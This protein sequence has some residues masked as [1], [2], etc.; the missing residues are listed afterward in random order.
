[1]VEII[2]KIR[3]RSPA[4]PYLDLKDA[5]EK[6]EGFYNIQD[7]NRISAVVATKDIGYEAGSSRGWRA[8][9]SLISFG[10]LDEEGVTDKREVWLSELG[11]EIFHYGSKDSDEA[12]KAIR[13]AALKPPI[14]A[15]LWDLWSRSGQLPSDDHMKRFLV[16]NKAFNPKAVDTFIK[17]FV[18]TL[19]YA[20][21]IQG[22]KIALDSVPSESKRRNTGVPGSRNNS[23]ARMNTTSGS[24]QDATIPLIGGA[25]AILSIPRPLSKK[26]YDLI[27]RWLTLMEP[28]LTESDGATGLDE[29]EASEE[30]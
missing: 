7:L 10:L 14:H 11:K 2:S 23:G 20:G 13:V 6:T 15:E 18:D 29:P 27:K 1:M 8:L 28:S 3:L 30:E 25:T 26:N 19:T 9:A 4:Y 17:E 5:V 12:K 21:F 24:L 22:S 16:Q